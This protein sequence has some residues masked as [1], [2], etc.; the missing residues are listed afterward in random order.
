MPLTSKK[1]DYNNEDE[2]NNETTR[3]TSSSNFVPLKNAN[4]NKKPALEYNN[5]TE[6]SYIEQGLTPPQNLSQQEKNFLSKVDPN[7]EPITRTV[8]KIV[9]YKA[10]DYSSPKRERKEYLIYYENWT[11]RDWLKRI[12]APVTDHIE[13]K[14]EEVITEPVYQQQELTGYKYSGKRQI[15]YI[16]FSKE[17][18]DEIIASS[19]GSS[20]ETIKYLFSEDPLSYEFPYN[21]F[22][23]RSYEE[24]ASMLIAQG[25]PKSILQKQQLEKYQQEQKQVEEMLTTS[26]TNNTTTTT[27][28]QNK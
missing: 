26:K 17:K 12:V 2:A 19:M 13:G 20:K 10:I 28:K 11:G 4:K 5:R 14:F 15:H 25:G 23:N 27:N 1:V 6:K 18:V 22:V 16:P 24:L 3:T 9:R 8:T 7:V 21:E